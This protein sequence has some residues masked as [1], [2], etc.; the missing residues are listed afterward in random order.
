M[1]FNPGDKVSVI[2]F[3]APMTV[4]SVAGDDVTVLEYDVK[5]KAMRRRTYKAA[6]L[7]PTP[8]RRALRFVF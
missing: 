3:A 2:G 8:K 6:T 4:E 7:R 1:A 5:R